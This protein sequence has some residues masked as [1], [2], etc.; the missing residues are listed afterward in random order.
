MLSIK[1]LSFKTILKG[2]SCDIPRKKTTLLLGNS[3]SGKTSLL[4]CL[5]QIE[6][7]YEGDILYE[8][9]PLKT[10]SVRARCQIIGYV[11]QGYALF[12]HK[13]VL[14][15]CLEP[16]RLSGEKK[17]KERV[18]ALLASLG[19]ES[20]AYARPQQLSGGQQQRVAIAR[21]LA[22]DPAFLLLD[23]PTSALDEGNTALF[24]G[25][26]NR[27]LQAGK[28]L[29]IATHDKGLREL[30]ETEALCIRL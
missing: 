19:I 15:N 20:Y 1:N 2:I 18:L 13:N 4:R 26:L 29:I 17:G 9:V 3:G 24:V 25:I 6:R 5:A 23:E 30:I 10:M 12:P 22:L 28:G 16:L 7:Q 21:A 11:A 14:D 27:L 8:G